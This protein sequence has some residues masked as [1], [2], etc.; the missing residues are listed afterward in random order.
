MRIEATR[1]VTVNGTITANGIDGISQDGSGSGGGIYI[2]CRT[3][4]GDATGILRANGGN[5]EL[6]LGKGAGGGGGRIAVLRL[7]HT[8]QGTSSVT[9]GTAYSPHEGEDGTIFWGQLPIPRGSIF[10]IR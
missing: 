6:V 7:F 8:Y 5:G 10:S 3:F 9:G 4:A 1:K 2:R